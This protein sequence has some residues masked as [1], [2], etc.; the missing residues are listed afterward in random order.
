MQGG[1]CPF[2]YWGAAPSEGD[3]AARAFRRGIFCVLPFKAFPKGNLFSL[4]ALDSFPTGE[5]F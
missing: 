2:Y 3:P 4:A 1:R 5:A